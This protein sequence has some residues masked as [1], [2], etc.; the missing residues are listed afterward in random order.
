MHSNN[1][2]NVRPSIKLIGED[3]GGD[4]GDMS[5]QYLEEVDLGF[6]V[7]YVD[8]NFGAS[9][10]NKVSLSNRFVVA[11]YTIPKKKHPT[12][13]MNMQRVLDKTG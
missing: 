11:M 6:H 13:V 4:A 1:I 2:T 3:F 12:H 7:F 8:L 10:F 9:G 5:L